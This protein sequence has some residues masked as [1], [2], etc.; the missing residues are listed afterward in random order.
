MEL[1]K[2]NRD[3]MAQGILICRLEQITV[4]AQEADDDGDW[5]PFPFEVN[6]LEID[7]TMI[8]PAGPIDEE[9]VGDGAEEGK[10][11]I[12]DSP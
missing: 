12:S 11:T 5:V 9:H 6:L 10:Y 7:S 2:K 4:C 1:I 3:V 8:D